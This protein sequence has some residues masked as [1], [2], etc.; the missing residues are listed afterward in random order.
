MLEILTQEHKADFATRGFS[1]RR[2]H[3][4]ATLLAAGSALPFYNEQALAQRADRP[5]IPADAVRINANENPMGPCPEAA[6]AIHAIVQR[7][8][9]Y[10]NEENSVLPTLLAEQEGVKKNYVTAFG[11]SSD[12][13]HRAVLSFTAKDRPYVVGDPGYE[14]GARAAEFIGA[15]VIRV[16]LVP[17]S[18]KHDVKA[19][20]AAAPNAGLFYICNPNNPTGTITPKEDLEWLVENKPA[21]SV[22]MIDE[23]YIHLSHATMSSYLVAADKDVVIL[24]T[25]SK[26][27]GMAGLRAG[28]AIAKPDLLAK[29]SNYGNGMLPVTGMA[30]AAASLRVKTLVEERRK[31]I[32][33]IRED[34]FGFLAKN[35]IEFVT[36]YANMFMMN[37]KRSGQDF[38]ND[39]AAQKVM[40]GRVWKA[41]PNWVRVSVGTREEMAKFKEACLKC[42]T[43]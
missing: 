36:S 14:A 34:T 3:R 29:L 21:G 13:L 28:A 18:F 17:G 24:R 39:M 9:R 5:P 22:V 6:E 32:A 42:Y 1:R 26:L 20:V 37:V 27:Y 16:P 15:P 7:G 41:C 23:A 2:F 33:D 10:L 43:A 38:F 30:G 31:I 19:M 40:I 25:F 11:G 12:P 4:M 35:N 8:G